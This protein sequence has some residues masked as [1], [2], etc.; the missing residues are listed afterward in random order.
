[1]YRTLF[2]SLSREDST[3]PFILEDSVSTSGRFEFLQACLNDTATFTSDER[4]QIQAWAAHP[5]FKIWTNDLVPGARLI[6]KDTIR[7][8]F[9]KEQE[10][11]WGYFYSHFGKDFNRLGCPL[12]LRNYSWCIFY[13]G[14]HC[15][16]LC[17]SGQLA[18]YR[19]EGSHW[20]FVKNWGSWVS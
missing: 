12:F 6:P 5:P 15:G 17:G 16:W 7:S 8:V 14:N 20:V 18:L 9:S 2:F 1:M 13:S 10:N 3:A 19:K 11:G 4:Q